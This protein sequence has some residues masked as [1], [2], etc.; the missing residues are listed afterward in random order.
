MSYK[1]YKSNTK[2]HEQEIKVFYREHSSGIWHGIE[3]LPG[4]PYRK[5]NLSFNN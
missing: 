2:F 5:K 4:N 3:M 1:E